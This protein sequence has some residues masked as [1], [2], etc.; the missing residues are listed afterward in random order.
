LQHV[1]LVLFINGLFDDK[2]SVSDS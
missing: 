2:V 1:V